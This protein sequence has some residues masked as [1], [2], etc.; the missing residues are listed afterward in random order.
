MALSVMALRVVM[1]TMSFSGSKYFT[2]GCLVAG[3]VVVYAALFAIT[4][5]PLLLELVD[6]ARARRTRMRA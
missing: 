6:L 5:R 3:A 4:Q 2:L 1:P